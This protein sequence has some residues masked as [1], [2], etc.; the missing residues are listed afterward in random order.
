MDTE[1]IKK[2]AKE[3]MDSFAEA[4]ENVETTEDHGIDR[5]HGTRTPEESELTEGF[6]ERM[7]KNAPSKKGRLVAVEKKKW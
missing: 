3:I 2:R 6:P 4:M 7:L 5:E 1:Q